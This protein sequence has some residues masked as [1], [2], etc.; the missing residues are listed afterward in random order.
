M[1][2][3]LDLAVR[4]AVFII[5]LSLHVE[6]KCGERKCYLQKLPFRWGKIIYMFL[7]LEIGTS[8]SLQWAWVRLQSEIQIGCRS[9]GTSFRPFYCPAA[10]HFSGAS[11]V[12]LFFQAKA[13]GL[14][15][16]L[17]PV[18]PQSCSIW[19]SLPRSSLPEPPL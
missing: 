1:R 14:I 3:V 7:S 9:K 11:S 16:L 5:N 12:L 8:R 15:F 18:L 10:D 17:P 4:K 6:E 2:A 13:M 19:H